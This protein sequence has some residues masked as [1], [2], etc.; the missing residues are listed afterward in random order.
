MSKLRNTLFIFCRECEAELMAIN[1]RIG[2]TLYLKT[3][4]RLTCPECEHHGEYSISGEY[5]AIAEVEMRRA[6][7]RKGRF[8]R[9][10]EGLQDD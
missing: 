7:A 9:K 1:T 3:C 10:G 6:N 8:F 5:K 2:S 4:L